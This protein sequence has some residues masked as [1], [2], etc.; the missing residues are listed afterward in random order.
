MRLNIWIS[1]GYYHFIFYRTTI[2]RK[3]WWEYSCLHDG[4]NKECDDDDKSESSGSSYMIIPATTVKRDTEA[5]STRGHDVEQDGNISQLTGENRY[6]CDEIY[7]FNTF[8]ISQDTE[9]VD[10]S[11]TYHEVTVARHSSN[12]T[13]HEVTVAHH[14]SNDAYHEVTVA[15][16]SSNDAYHEVTVAHH[17]SNDTY[18]EVTVAHHSSNDA[19]HEVTVAH[20][21]SN[22]AYHE[23][24]VAHHS[25]NDAYHE[26]TVAHHSSTAKRNSLQ[27]LEVVYPK[28]YEP[29]DRPGRRRTITQIQDYEDNQNSLRIENSMCE[30]TKCDNTTACTAHEN[31][32]SNL[33]T[34][35][36]GLRTPVVI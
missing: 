23:V 8:M 17:S 31:V 7:N 32:I 33:S 9:K 15:H 29:R 20:H 25:S 16:H 1:V 12:D 14:S 24:T 2:W 28:D 6:D 30:E 13:Y 21:S 5:L 4:D 11:D 26:V 27:T 3:A 34:D 19:Y 22:D 36:L 18:H 10:D 35:V